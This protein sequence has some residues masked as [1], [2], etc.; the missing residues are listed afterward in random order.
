MSHEDLE[1]RRLEA[2]IAKIDAEAEALQRHRWTGAID[3]IKVTG[4]IIATIAGLYAAITT[5]RVTQL[6]T[7]IALS[8]RQQAEKD[9]G[10][11]LV[12]RARANSELAQ[13]NEAKAMAERDLANLLAK[14][15]LARDEIGRI[16]TT[17]SPASDR[18]ALA[19]SRWES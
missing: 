12:A 4:A 8:E 14:V 2:E 3:F 17:G 16:G 10:I 6:E 1:R 18:S 15:Q 13:A 9:R 5:Y 19:K 7:R 11:A